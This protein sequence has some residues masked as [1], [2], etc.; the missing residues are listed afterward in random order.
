MLSRNIRCGSSLM[1]ALQI[2]NWSRN[3]C[4]VVREH[5]RIFVAH[6]PATIKW[7]DLKD[8]CHNTF[9]DMPVAYCR[10]ATDRD[11]GRSLGHGL[12]QMENADDVEKAITAL[13]GST[14]EGSTLIARKD[15]RPEDRKNASRELNSARNSGDVDVKKLRVFV[16]NI[17]F[18]FEWRDLKDHSR[19]ILPDIPVT[20]CAISKDKTTGMSNG[21]GIIQFAN[22]S[23]VAPAIAA[24]NGSILGGNTLFVREDKKRPVLVES[25]N[26]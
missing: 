5:T 14:L 3:L 15:M 8:H 17:P 16:A 11:S 21:H 18:A 2:S 24:L 9:P 12:V 22:P 23:D 19:K 7:Q 26:N 1:K 20:F 13:N 4:Q 10:I 6:I 25:V